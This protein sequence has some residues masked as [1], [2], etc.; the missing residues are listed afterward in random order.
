MQILLDDG[1]VFLFDLTGSLPY[2]LFFYFP[3]SRASVVPG[4]F[5]REFIIFVCSPMLQV[6]EWT[7][8]FILA[9][10]LN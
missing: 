3:S 1:L 5:L 8:S 10:D 6:V 2:F 4:I 7:A 9:V